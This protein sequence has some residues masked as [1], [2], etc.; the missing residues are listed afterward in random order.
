M[1]SL[2]YSNYPGFGQQLS[3]S[4]NYS[5]AVRVPGNPNLIK[6]SGQGGWNPQTGAIDPP[7]SQAIINAQI[8]Q[9]FS[10]VDL[11]LRTAGS[12]RGWDD[13][14]LAR[15]YYVG[16]GEEASFGKLVETLKEWC[17]NHR[18]VVT[19]VEVQKLALEGMRIEIEVEAYLAE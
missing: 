14:Y 2:T 13:V 9:A 19:A 3:D 12:K 1:S 18:P 4:T 5:Q 16:L 15:I 8:S 6:I 10:N 7:T 11:T 17:P